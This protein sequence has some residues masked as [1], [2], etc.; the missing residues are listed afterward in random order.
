M[1]FCHGKLRS[2]SAVRRPMH[3]ANAGRCARLAKT[4]VLAALAAAFGLGTFAP[5]ADAIE[6]MDGRLRI[7]GFIQSTNIWRCG[8][9]S[10]SCDDSTSLFNDRQD[11]GL[12]RQKNEGQLEVG[13]L[14]AENLGPI[15]KIELFTIVNGWW[16]TV[17]DLNESNFGNGAGDPVSLAPGLAP[18]VDGDFVGRGPV[19]LPFPK[20][21]G[22]VAR[23]LPSGADRFL[24]FYTDSDINNEDDLATFLKFREAYVDVQ[25]NNLVGDDDLFLRLGKQQVSWG[26]TDFFRLL[27]VVNPVDFGNH[28]FLEPFED[29]K[30][31]QTMVHAVWKFNRTGPFDDLSLEIDWNLNAFT[32]NQLGFPGGPF[33]FPGGSD[34]I[35]AFGLINQSFGGGLSEVDLPGHGFKDTEIGGR[36]QGVYE[37]V[38]WSVAAW[39]SWSDTPVFQLKEITPAGVDYR[40]NVPRTTVVGGSLDWF[41]DFTDSVWRLEVA[42]EFN[43][44]FTNTL[45]PDGTEKTDVF[46]WVLGWDRPT[47]IRFL[48]NRRTFLLTAQV[49]HTHIFDHDEE[50]VENVL[51]DVSRAGFAGNDEDTFV[52]TFVALGFYMSDRLQPSAFA[53]YDTA[54]QGGLVGANVTYLLSDNLDFTVGFNGFYGKAQKADSGPL[55]FLP[56]T[57]SCPGGGSITPAMRAADPSLEQCIVRVRSELPFGVFREGAGMLRGADEVF[58]RFRFRF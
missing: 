39:R 29:F 34:Q 11:G 24:A 9:F 51:G 20:D 50:T 5:P 33:R 40:I 52:F 4:F 7:N 13:F 32:P 58:A 49:F 1:L 31:P 26:K 36:L 17:Y 19:R 35:A 12:V 15:S 55:G 44:V 47:W 22:D 57:G 38:T 2:R 25:L 41:E 23:A 45:R 54:G 27:D 48:N 6:L 3:G 56:G 42:H 8:D 46:R 28:F 14:A 16:D 53:T 30:I 43:A 18:T 21:P 37:G 10:F